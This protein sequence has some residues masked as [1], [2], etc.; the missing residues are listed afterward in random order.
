MVR[1]ALPRFQI[2]VN[3]TVMIECLR[4]E[5]KERLLFE[6][7]YKEIARHLAEPYSYHQAEQWQ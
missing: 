5:M 2:E 6:R 3:L 7:T 4:F 1:L